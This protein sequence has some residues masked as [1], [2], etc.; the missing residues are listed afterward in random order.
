MKEAQK[1]VNLVSINNKITIINNNNKKVNST[2]KIISSNIGVSKNGIKSIHA[3]IFLYFLEPS[4][5]SF[6]CIPLKLIISMIL[7]KTIQN[8]Q[9]TTEKYVQKLL[10]CKVDGAQPRS[11]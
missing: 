6:E 4:P 3:L 7:R 5:I 1:W 2:E 8:L 11:V 9:K 10:I